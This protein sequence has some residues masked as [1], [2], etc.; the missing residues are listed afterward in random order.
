MIKKLAT[1]YIG[2][3]FTSWFNLRVN[4][5]L[6]RT[7]ANSLTFKHK[8]TNYSHLPNYPFHTQ[9]NVKDVGRVNLIVKSGTDKSE[10][11]IFFLS[12]LVLFLFRLVRSNYFTRFCLHGRYDT[13]YIRATCL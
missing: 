11:Y 8:K 4:I 10:I 7:S 2:I 1:I 5:S 12:K 3:N 6:Q 13:I 9:K